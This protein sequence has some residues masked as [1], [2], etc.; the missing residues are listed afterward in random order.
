[1]DGTIAPLPDL[2]RL[3]RE[4][5]ALLLIDE[6]HATGLVGDVRTVSSELV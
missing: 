5:E 4:H 6:C 2:C 3:A 1:M